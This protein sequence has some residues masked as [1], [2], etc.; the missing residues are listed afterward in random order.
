MAS[1]IDA[2]QPASVAA[3]AK[4]TDSVAAIAARFKGASLAQPAEV[5]Q[6]VR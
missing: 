5:F 6:A 1:K 4:Q 3:D 2:R